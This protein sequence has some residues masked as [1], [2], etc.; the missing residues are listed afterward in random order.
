MSERQTGFI[1]D[2][3]TGRL[4]DVANKQVEWAKRVF[5]EP[6]QISGTTNLL[7]LENSQIESSTETMLYTNLQSRDSEL[8][9][10]LL[11][12]RKADLR[13]AIEMIRQGISK[14]ERSLALLRTRREALDK[15]NASEPNPQLR[16]S[17]QVFDDLDGQVAVDVRELAFL[18]QRIVAISALDYVLL[19]FDENGRSSRTYEQLMR[20]V[21]QSFRG[22]ARLRAFTGGFRDSLALRVPKLNPYAHGKGFEGL[23]LLCAPETS[24]IV[25]DQCTATYLRHFLETINLLARLSADYICEQETLSIEDWFPLFALL[26]AIVE[27][28]HFCNFELPYF[29]TDLAVDSEDA[30]LIWAFNHET[31]AWEPAPEQVGTS[32]HLKRVST[33]IALLITEHGQLL[34]CFSLEELNRVLRRDVPPTY[35]STSPLPQFSPYYSCGLS[36]FDINPTNQ[37]IKFYSAIASIGT[38]LEQLTAGQE[39]CAAIAS[40]VLGGPLETLIGLAEFDP[41]A[42]GI[43]GQAHPLNGLER[44]RLLSTFWQK[45]GRRRSFYMLGD[46][47][48]K[49]I[50]KGFEAIGAP[51][52]VHTTF[53]TGFLN[54][55]IAS[56]ASTRGEQLADPFS[57]LIIAD[58]MRLV[59]MLNFTWEI[60]ADFL[61][62]LKDVHSQG[63][64]KRIVESLPQFSTEKINELLRRFNPKW[65][66]STHWVWSL[67]RSSAPT[68]W[69]F[70]GKVGERKPW[71][72]LLSL[73]PLHSLALMLRL[74]CETVRLVLLIE[75]SGAGIGERLVTDAE[76]AGQTIVHGVHSYLEGAAIPTVLSDALNYYFDTDIRHDIWLSFTSSCQ[77]HLR[78][79]VED[80]TAM[81][82]SEQ[83]IKGLMCVVRQLDLLYPSNSLAAPPATSELVNVPPVIRTP[84]AISPITEASAE[85]FSRI[86]FELIAL[87]EGE[88]VIFLKLLSMLARRE[89]QE[90][91]YGA[92]RI[93]ALIKLLLPQQQQRI[94]LF[95]LPKTTQ[96]FFRFL[97][98]IEEEDTF[99]SESLA[100][101][102]G[103]AIDYFEQLDSFAQ[104]LN[105]LTGYLP[106][107]LPADRKIVEDFIQTTAPAN[108][109]LPF[110]MFF[111]C[112]QL[113]MDICANSADR[114]YQVEAA[115]AKIRSYL[116]E[117]M[118]AQFEEPSIEIFPI[119][120]G[121]ISCRDSRFFLTGHNQSFELAFSE[122]DQ[123]MSNYL[124]SKVASIK[125]SFATQMLRS[126]F[127]NFHFVVQ[128]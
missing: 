57:S 90:F 10:Q 95:T 19:A 36:E 26:R 22:Q 97:Q 123:P 64:L 4:G 81:G 66:Q 84:Y 27:F 126:E 68:L 29:Y 115:T 52:P 114:P 41:R 40:S 63:K 71:D 88:S 48:V 100:S 24:P 14:R 99:D 62:K 59:E 103:S 67:L 128:V 74:F 69:D 65:L 124:L 73:P 98:S 28:F 118:G 5:A 91:I 70:W 16:Y 109:D 42:F 92:D 104:T 53:L 89:T 112:D 18:R 78:Q 6:I 3:Q 56:V 23:L 61:D 32:R 17:R 47:Y 85:L 1:F 101:L 7:A 39:S 96:T 46:S 13:Q 93:H 75:A 60:A 35:G 77:I 15:I 117:Q 45:T 76:T 30:H 9:V 20:L 12:R 51:S 58:Q 108:R 50:T 25:I 79:L 2:F 107:I 116:R 120:G 37:Q 127:A 38:I 106:Y 105:T 44:F 49:K 82:A 80:L 121:R 55:T 119:G 111:A 21:G 43:A 125:F 94:L 110:L 72:H 11:E 113:M 86:Y 87:P 54:P 34:K 31:Q 102:K 83:H 122:P 33:E 8:G